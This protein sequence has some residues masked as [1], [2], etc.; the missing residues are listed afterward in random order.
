MTEQQEKNLYKAYLEAKLN[1][2]PQMLTGEVGLICGYEDEDG[3]LI[4]EVEEIE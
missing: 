4:I 3:R 2:Q 1:H